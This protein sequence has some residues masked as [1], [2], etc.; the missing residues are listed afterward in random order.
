MTDR[1]EYTFA[2]DLFYLTSMDIFYAN[3]LY[4]FGVICSDNFFKFVEPKCFN[5]RMIE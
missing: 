5:F 1:D 2:F 4:S 3:S